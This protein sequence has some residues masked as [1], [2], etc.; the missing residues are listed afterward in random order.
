VL[1]DEGRR[2]VAQAERAQSL[3][4]RA[5]RGE[6]GR[7]VLGVAESASYA[8]LPE[9]LREYRRAYPDVDLA[10]RMMTTSAQ[11]AALRAGDID[12]GLARTPISAD[13]LEVRT[14]RVDAVA[15]LVPDQHRLVRCRSVALREL[16]GE[17]L[18]VYPT[19]PRSSWTA[20]MLSVLRNAGVEPGQ[21]HEASDAFA[22][23]AF[24]AA[25]LGVTL[26]PGGRELFTRPG[27][28]WRPVSRPAPLT[29]LVLLHGKERTTPTVAALVGVVKRL[30]PRQREKIRRASG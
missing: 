18:V 12:A 14:I 23:V 11:I 24:V 15:V 1:V 27:V 21:T 4:Q 2:V 5:G 7:L 28:V 26:V 10:V 6:V 25:G 16:A 30:W 20:F 17:A 3:T 9:L 8:I 13:D 29:R 22:A 19:G